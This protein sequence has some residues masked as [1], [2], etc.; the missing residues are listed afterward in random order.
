M[1]FDGDVLFLFYL[2][3]MWFP[4]R[5]FWLNRPRVQA[6]AQADCAAHA[7]AGSGWQKT[8]NVVVVVVVVVVWSGV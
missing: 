5:I 1:K 4:L 2:I 7:I 3:V 6:G 8:A